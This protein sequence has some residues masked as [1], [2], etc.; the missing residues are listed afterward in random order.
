MPKQA[1]AVPPHRRLNL[2]LPSLSRRARVLPPAALVAGLLASMAL[3]LSAPPHQLVS[4][5]SSHINPLKERELEFR[6][7][8][9]A[10]CAFYAT[11]VPRRLQAVVERE[12]EVPKGT[13]L[14]LGTRT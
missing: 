12:A 5:A 9:L 14:S 1:P 10:A 11:S 2:L 8:S 4:R 7:Q 13:P 6:G 3:C